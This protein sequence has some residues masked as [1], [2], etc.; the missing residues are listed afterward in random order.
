MSRSA[1]SVDQRFDWI[2]AYLETLRVISV[3]ALTGD[4]PRL[5]HFAIYQ[6][7][8][9]NIAAD[10]HTHALAARAALPAEVLGRE[11]PCV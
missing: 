1:L 7:I 8:V 11:A 6:A 10:A 9:L 3:L 4:V 2:I 5:G